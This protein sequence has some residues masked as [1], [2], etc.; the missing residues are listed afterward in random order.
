MR[1]SIRLMG[2][3]AMKCPIR[4]CAVLV[5]VGGFVLI[6][7]ILQKIRPVRRMGA[8]T[9]GSDQA[10]PRLQTLLDTVRL[11]NS[12]LELKELT[13]I[14]LEVVRAEIPVERISVFLV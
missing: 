14:I 5:G 10:I 3:F 12:T 11:L 4:P 6:A 1:H 2:S 8:M 9:D 13:G 7:E